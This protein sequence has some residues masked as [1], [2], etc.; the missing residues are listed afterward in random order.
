[1]A[2]AGAASHSPRLALGAQRGPGR[3]RARRWVGLTLICWRRAAE[4]GAVGGGGG[5]EEAPRGEERAAEPRSL[6]F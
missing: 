6:E 5:R 2:P 3:G 1:M 4:E